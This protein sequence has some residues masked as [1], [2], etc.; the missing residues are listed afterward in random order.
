[1]ILKPLLF[2]WVA[3]MFTLGSAL[4]VI[5]AAVLALCYVFLIAFTFVVLM[6]IGLNIITGA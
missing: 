4:I 2:L 1:M 6:K 3:L 5:R